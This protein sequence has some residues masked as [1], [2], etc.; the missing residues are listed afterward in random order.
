MLLAYEAVCAV[1]LGFPAVRT[2]PAA[3]LSSVA[4]AEDT[5]TPT[6]AYQANTLRGLG[7]SPA[8]MSQLVV[9]L[10]AALV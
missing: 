4:A 3:G 10:T 2:M 5:L 8:A 9:W 7:V 6:M 1:P